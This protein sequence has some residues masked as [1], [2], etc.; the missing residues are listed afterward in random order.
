MYTKTLQD[1][2]R[3][4]DDID[5]MT[6]AKAIEYL[7]TLD[8]TKTLDCYIDGDTHG[9]ELV[10]RLLYEVP[11][12]DKE[13]LK[14]LEKVLGDQIQRREK[15]KKYYI[16]RGNYDRIP[17]IDASIASAK[18]KLQKARMKYGG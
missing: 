4:L 18:E 10:S 8:Q 11:M 12:T 9:C 17:A 5:G 3:W 15:E 13:I 2:V 16:D 6:V 1:N 7:K 14:H